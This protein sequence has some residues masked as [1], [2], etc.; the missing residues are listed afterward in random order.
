MEN[1]AP[2]ELLKEYGFFAGF[3]YA[4]MGIILYQIAKNRDQLTFAF[5]RLLDQ[6][7]EY[8]KVEIK[9]RDRVFRQSISDRI[10]SI[11]SYMYV[12][13]D[14]SP[15]RISILKYE[16]IPD[17]KGNK[18]KD[19]YLVWILHEAA[20]GVR[21][22]KDLWQGIALGR[23]TKQYLIDLVRSPLGEVFVD[24]VEALEEGDMRD[25]LVTNGVNSFV[26]I[27]LHDDGN[28]HYWVF[29]VTFQREPPIEREELSTIR[30]CSAN[31][32]KLLFE[33]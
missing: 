28:S 13:M 8:L 16:F 7:R 26:N 6:L 11:Y 15:I 9:H 12:L 32:R 21:H 19:K 29:S 10:S 30:L 3:A 2:F 18:E 17:K 24:D 25:T 1:F 20:F 14:M 22:I 27:L 23:Q 5:I 4:V 33:K 31:I